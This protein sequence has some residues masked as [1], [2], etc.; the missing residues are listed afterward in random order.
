LLYHLENPV[1]AMR[2]VSAVT[3]HILVVDTNTILAG[4]DKET[5]LWRMSFP[6]PVASVDAG[7]SSTG[8]W[9]NREY[10]Q[11]KPNAVAVRR[12]LELVGFNRVR[13]LEPQ[14][15]G[16]PEVYREGQ[17]KTFIAVRE[18]V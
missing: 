10:C 15:E 9:R 8:L 2:K 13:L 7:L 14:V 4:D 18:S 11:L 5:P 17:R 3:G 1:L 6:S 12:L 16:L